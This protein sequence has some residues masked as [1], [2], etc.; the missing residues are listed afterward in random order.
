M[1]A[2][3]GLAIMHPESARAAAKSMLAARHDARGR[4]ND[5]AVS[6]ADR[7][8]FLNPVCRG[9]VP[10]RLYFT[11]R[12]IVRGAARASVGFAQP[13]TRISSPAIMSVTS[14]AAEATS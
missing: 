14:S 1:C 10:T 9:A 5:F 6:M 3:L 11:S 8:I 2:R 7:R 13:F 12:A 4:S